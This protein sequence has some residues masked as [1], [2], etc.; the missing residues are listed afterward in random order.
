MYSGKDALH[1]INLSL[2]QLNKQVNGSEQ[3]IDQLNNERISLE[4]LETDQFR[5]LA[6]LRLDLLA[7]GDIIKRLDASEQRAEIL[8]K[9]RV[10]T[11]QNLKQ[12][13]SLLDQ[14]REKLEQQRDEQA[15]LVDQASQNLDQRE[16]EIQKKL[17]TDSHYQEKLQHSKNADRVADHAE[18]KT[19]ISNNDKTEKGKPYEEDVFFMY[20]WNRK[21]GSQDYHVNRFVHYFDKK[22][23][24]FCRYDKARANYKMLTELPVRLG[25]H[26]KVK[27]QLADDA[28]Q[29]L[30]T[31]EQKAASEAGISDLL[32]QLDDKEQD[33]QRAEQ[34]IDIF[35]EKAVT[36][37]HRDVAFITGDDQELQDILQ[38]LVSSFQNDDL[39]ALYQDAAETPMP[40]DD[41]I[42]RELQ[43][44]NHSQEQL[45]STQLQ[46][47]QLLKEQQQRQMGLNSIKRLFKQSRYDAI[48]SVFSDGGKINLLLNQYINGIFD[49]NHLWIQLQKM[50]K[51]QA[52]YSDPFFGSGTFPE[53]VWQ[54]G[55][56]R[57]RRSGGFSFPRRS[58]GS[59]LGEIAGGVLEGLARGAARGGS[60]GGSLGGGSWGGGG[61]GGGGFK[62]GGGF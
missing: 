52:V 7:T 21:Y 42:V 37:Q 54:G 46:Q 53:G 23:A 2:D 56:S 33:L 61:G 45:V 44:I 50:Q 32:S 27:R 39:I 22:I 41:L 48:T 16:A 36:L 28:F 12:Q 15:Q 55:R 5:K 20:L 8:L 31:I 35:D 19:Q 40:E 58:S 6:K 9:K 38:L 25:E 10:Q 29:I 18:E 34:E 43:N 59:L 26:A 13:I 57:S 62:T 1:S 17:S 3:A 24:Y 14:Q 4:K 51:N 49:S 60:S 11:R 47:R 30:K